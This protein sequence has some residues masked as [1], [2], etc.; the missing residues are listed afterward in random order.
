MSIDGEGREGDYANI[1]NDLQ[2]ILDHVSLTYMRDAT[3]KPIF[4]PQLRL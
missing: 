1:N 2:D 4:F 3:Y